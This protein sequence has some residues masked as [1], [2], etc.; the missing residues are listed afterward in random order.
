MTKVIGI[1]PAPSKKNTIF[2]GEK[3]NECDY[4]GLQSILNELKKNTQEKILICW[5]APLSFSLD[6]IT[7]KMSPF[8]KRK[9]EY[10]FS[11]EKGYKAPP[12][13]SVLGFAGCPHWAITQYLLGYPRTSGFE[14]DFNPPFELISKNE[15][16]V[17]KSITE[18]HPAVAIWLWLKND[19]KLNN[20][21]YKKK[22]NESIRKKLI[23]T[24]KIKNIIPQNLGI[25]SDD[26]LDAFIAWKLG[27]EWVNNSE[28]VEILGNNETGSFLLPKKAEVFDKFKKF[29]VK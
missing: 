5:D 29:E 18:V 15:E 3:F 2:N 10:F 17:S 14:K 7:D 9:I 12:G 25:K 16:E 6:N 19:L 1:D 13:I 26:E 27:V 24:L 8:F 23:D 11:Q 21:N 22:K 20:W 4:K 28:K